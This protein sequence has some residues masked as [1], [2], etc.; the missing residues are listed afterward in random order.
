MRRCG[1]IREVRGTVDEAMHQI[2][3]DMA[4]LLA[5]VGFMAFL[6]FVVAGGM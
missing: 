5:C 1:E 3:Q 4:A 2:A 6:V